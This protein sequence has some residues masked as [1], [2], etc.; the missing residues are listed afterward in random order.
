MFSFKNINK[1]WMTSLLGYL[2]IFACLVSVFMKAA[3]WTDAA[4]GMAI[5]IT[6]LGLPDPKLP[7]GTGVVGVLVL[8]STLA[9]GGCVT[10]QKCLDKYGT[11]APPTTLAIT[12]SIR[13]PVT[14]TT[15]ADSLEAGFGLDS[16][17]AAPVGDTLRLVSVGSLAR[18][19]I[20]KSPPTKPGG[21]Q[22]LNARVYVPP[23]VIH[24]TV[25]QVVTLY[26]ECP[27]TFTLAPSPPWY[28]RWWSYYQLG[29]TYLFSA[30]LLL[31][32]FGV[33]RRSRS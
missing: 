19:H 29:C 8:L 2:V 9:F 33:F 22:R 32:L 25:T 10:Y 13:V 6:L 5:G 30:A 17:A 11:Q 3:S 28:R 18:L 12:D 26:G 1:G 24:D 16:L 27:P 15:Q 23:Q 7:G 4:V 31:W 20:W 21:S 14:V